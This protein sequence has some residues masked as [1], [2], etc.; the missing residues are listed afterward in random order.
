M[1]NNGLNWKKFSTK[2]FEIMLPG[3]FIGGDPKKDKKTIE[4]QIAKLP[5]KYHKYYKTILIGGKT[6]FIV[7]DTK[8]DE[9]DPIITVVSAAFDKLPL[10]SF[11]MSMEKYLKEALG[12]LGKNAEIVEKGVV[13][14]Q[15]YQ[16]A[17]VVV[18][19][20]EN[21]GFLRKPGEIQQI[22]V[23]FSIKLKT[24]FW[25]F[26]FAT[27]PARYEKELPFFEQSMYSIVIN[28]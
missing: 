8:I 13:A 10:F 26:F 28:D 2:E 21:R 18:N 23:F 16:A 27:T 14:L 19:N 25:D 17:R 9:N 24:K 3:T 5:E 12:H 11:G 6:P 20:R 1:E 4:A 15:N 7:A 22:I